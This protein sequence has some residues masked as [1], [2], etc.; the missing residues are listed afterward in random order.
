MKKEQVIKLKSINL[1][2]MASL[3]KLLII[4]IIKIK[5]IINTISIHLLNNN[6]IIIKQFHLEQNIQF[7][8]KQLKEIKV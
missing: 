5:V 7:L 6:L 1:M 2:K 8:Q 3:N 4:T